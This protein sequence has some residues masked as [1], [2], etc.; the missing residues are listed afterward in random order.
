LQGAPGVHSKRFA[1]TPGL[2]GKALD[3][4]N[5]THLLTLLAQV[6]DGARGAHYTCAAV[7]HFP[8]GRRVSALGVRSGRILDAPRGPHGFGYDP[9]FFDTAMGQSFGEMDP[10]LKNLTSHRSRAFRA[11]AGLL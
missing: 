8:N 1:R 7:A 10:A 2:D 6:S 11:L 3:Q 4:A 9:L 5:N